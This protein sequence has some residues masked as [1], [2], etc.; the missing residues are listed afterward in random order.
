VIITVP[1]ET[2]VISPVED[3]IT[4]MPANPELHVPPELGSVKLADDPV[5]IA[6]VP[7]MGNGNGFTVSWVVT[8]HPVANA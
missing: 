8:R 6:D 1:G 3:T 2:P 4:A 7:V 5:H